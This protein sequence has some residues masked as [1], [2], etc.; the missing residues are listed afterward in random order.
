M[1][2]ATVAEQTLPPGPMRTE[3]VTW[4]LSDESDEIEVDLAADGEKLDFRVLSG[5]AKT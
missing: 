3:T 2:D 5:T 4:P 1:T